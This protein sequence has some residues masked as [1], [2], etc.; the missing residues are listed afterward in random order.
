MPYLFLYDWKVVTMQSKS[1]GLGLQASRSWGPS[2]FFYEINSVFYFFQGPFLDCCVRS[3]FYVFL[4][5]S[6]F[7]GGSWWGEAGQPCSFNSP[8]LLGYNNRIR[9]RR[10][11]R[12]LLFLIFH[13]KATCSL[14]RFQNTIKN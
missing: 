4:A 10:L 8:C 9:Y 6:K 11:I 2:H 7:C 1:Y 12:S 5:G 13:H 3:Y 14:S